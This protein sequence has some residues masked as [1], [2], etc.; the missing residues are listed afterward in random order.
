MKKLKAFLNSTT[1]QIIGVLILAILI[2]FFDN[3]KGYYRFKQLCDE[4]QELIVYKKLEPNVGWQVDVNTRFHRDSVSEYL[5]FIPQIKFFRFQDYKNR[6][7]YDGWFVG[8]ERVPYERYNW[9]VYPRPS[10]DAVNFKFVEGNMDIS[11]IY[12]IERFTESVPGELRLS[13]LG[14]RVIDLRTQQKVMEISELWYGFFDRKKTLLDAPS[15]HLCRAYP[16]VF[17]AEIQQQFF[18]TQLGE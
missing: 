18:T 7:I 13:L 17:S 3:I 2:Y 6:Q 8:S 9:G 4:H 11:P 14:L 12:Q 10:G 16:S 5:Y 1:A 15:G